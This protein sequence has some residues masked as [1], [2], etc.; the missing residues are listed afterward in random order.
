MSDENLINNFMGEE[1]GTMDKKQQIKRILMA[2]IGVIVSGI[3]VG[4]FRNARFGTDPFQVFVNG[5]SNKV[6]F[7]D[8]GTLYMLIN[9]LMLIA[10]FFLNKKHI[11][12]STFINIFLLGYVVD[13]SDNIVACIVGAEPDMIVR[14]GLMVA[15]VVIL[16]FASA[17]YFTASLGVSTYDAV[18]LIL[19]ERKLGKFKYLRIATDCICVAI[20]FAFGAIVG[21]GTLVTAFFMGPLIDFF[22][23]HVARPFLYGKQDVKETD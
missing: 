22:N 18:A 13:F 5:I 8:F 9:L 6:P 19:E 14:I 1:I 10:I 16:C 15:A 17:M 21:V 2:F 4:L 11:G 3:S 20:G 23:V 7:I 12:I